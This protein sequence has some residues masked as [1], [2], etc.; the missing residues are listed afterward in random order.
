MATTTTK[1]NPRLPVNKAAASAIIAS[2]AQAHE[3]TTLFSGCEA[4]ARTGFHS[5]WAPI[6]LAGMSAVSAASSAYVR[7][8]NV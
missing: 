1:N 8:A 4:C 2:A 3:L 6:S 5:G 7:E